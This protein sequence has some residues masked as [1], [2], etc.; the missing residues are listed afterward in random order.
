V[1]IIYGAVL[2]N[3]IIGYQRDYEK[4][5]YRRL[6]RDQAIDANGFVF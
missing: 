2:D 5:S 4:E 1:K 6:S 3:P